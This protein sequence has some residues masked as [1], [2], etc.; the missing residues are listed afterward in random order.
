[1]SKITRS[2]TNH[3]D[4]KQSSKKALILCKVSPA[5]TILVKEG[6]TINHLI[7]KCFTGVRKWVLFWH[8]SYKLIHLLPPTYL[9]ISIS[10]IITLRT[11]GT[12]SLSCPTSCCIKQN[13][14]IHISWLP[15]SKFPAWNFHISR[16]IFHVHATM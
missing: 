8:P 11:E 1:M 9:S 13:A 5:D 16:I 7:H 4:S 10:I 2:T 12:L 3:I 14:K 15:I 6:K